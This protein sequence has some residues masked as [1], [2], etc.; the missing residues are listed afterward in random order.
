[1]IKVTVVTVTRTVTT[2]TLL[3]T[4]AHWQAGI[5]MMA[6]G[7]SPPHHEQSR[8]NMSHGRGQRRPAANVQPVTRESD[9]ESPEPT[10]TQLELVGTGRP[11]DSDS[12]RLAWQCDVTV[13]GRLGLRRTRS[14]GPAT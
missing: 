14:P 12:E 2:R 10:V 13:P 3:R 9:S 1:M 11:A 7:P 6:R 8:T 5:M 4:Q